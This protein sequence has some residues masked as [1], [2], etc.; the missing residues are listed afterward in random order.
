MVRDWEHFGNQSTTVSFSA[1]SAS[2]G[3]NA[4]TEVFACQLF[5]TIILFLYIFPNFL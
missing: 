2:D 3:M 4:Y 1:D 5:Y